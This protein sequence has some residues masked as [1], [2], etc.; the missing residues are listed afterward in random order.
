FAMLPRSALLATCASLLAAA[1]APADSFDY[2][3]NPVLT[4]VPGARGV[5]ELKQLTPDL[6]TDNDRVLP[7]T[8]A[9]LVVVR[10]N[11]GCFSKLLVE[12]RRQKIAADKTIPILYVERFVTYKEGEE[13]TILVSGQK[14]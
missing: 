7:R 10:T 6:I 3:T 4:R 2:Y 1:P 12:S 11:E 13:R 8:A 9:A 14:L 5:R